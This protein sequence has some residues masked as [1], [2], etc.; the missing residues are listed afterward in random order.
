MPERDILL[1]RIVLLLVTGVWAFAFVVDALSQAF[2]VPAT[3]HGLIGA[4]IAYFTLELK[5]SRT[6]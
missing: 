1:I 4:V 5:R 2:E 6:H 3:V